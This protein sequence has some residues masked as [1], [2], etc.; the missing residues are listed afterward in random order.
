MVNAGRCSAAIGDLAGAENY[1]KRAQART[2]NNPAAVYGLALLAYRAGRLDEARGWT[3]RLTQQPAPTPEALYLGMCIE[4]KNGDR[5]AESSYV[6]QLRN[7]FP[8]SAETK[9]L[10]AGACE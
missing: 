4:R 3:R 6:F 2:P 8:D 7:R 10:A 9:S 1:F 5:G